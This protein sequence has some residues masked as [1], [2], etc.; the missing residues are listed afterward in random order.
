MRG[1]QSIL[2][3]RVFSCVDASVVGTN[4]ASIPEYSTA[5]GV[6]RIRFRNLLTIWKASFLCCPSL[7]ACLRKIAWPM[8]TRKHRHMM[9]IE[10]AMKAAMVTKGF[11]PVMRVC[12]TAFPSPGVGGGV[13]ATRS[14]RAVL[15]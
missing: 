7:A 1:E 10:Q 5:E 3:I 4:L 9:N 11:R 2:S 15:S 8:T 13:G 12:G 14:L 6:E